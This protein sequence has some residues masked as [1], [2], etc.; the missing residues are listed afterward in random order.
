MQ[1]VTAWRFY[2]KNKGIKKITKSDKFHLLVHHV[3]NSLFDLAEGHRLVAVVQHG[4]HC[5]HAPEHLC[6]NLVLV[7]QGQAGRY[8][9]GEGVIPLVRRHLTAAGNMDMQTLSLV[10]VSERRHDV[11][12]L[13]HRPFLDSCVPLALLRLGSSLGFRC[14]LFG[15]NKR[16]TGRLDVTDRSFGWFTCTRSDVT[17][18]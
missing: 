15:P 1:L 13:L 7:G 3:L 18:R 12:L 4:H 9:L 16:R 8:G 5:V 11:D 2:H 17:S 14:E 10:V 6:Q